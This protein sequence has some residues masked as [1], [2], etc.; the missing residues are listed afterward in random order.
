MNQN[1]YCLIDE[2]ANPDTIDLWGLKTVNKVDYSPTMWS[3]IKQTKKLVDDWI[4]KPN[5]VNPEFYIKKII[6]TVNTRRDRITSWDVNPNEISSKLGIPD[7]KKERYEKKEQCREEYRIKCKEMTKKIAE[8]FDMIL[9]DKELFYN[10]KSLADNIIFFIP[11]YKI[12]EVDEFEWEPRLA[13]FNRRGYLYLSDSELGYG[14]D[15]VKIPNWDIPE[16]SSDYSK[17]ALKNKQIRPDKET[18]DDIYNWIQENIDLVMK[19]AG[20]RRNQEEAIMNDQRK[21]YADHPNG[22]WSGD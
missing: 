9:K 2:A 13:Y 19:E 11:E 14:E 6:N 20:H 1:G 5:D 21:Y 3:R 10:D 8:Q 18:L 17:S 22:N 15:A 12:N 16:D 7:I 4:D